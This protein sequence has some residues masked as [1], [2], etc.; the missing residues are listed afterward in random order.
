M[1][2]RYRDGAVP[3]V[4]TDPA[5]AAD[6]AALPARSRR[7]DRAEATTALELIWQRVRRLN[8]Y[9]EERAPWQLAKDPARAAALDE[10][11]ASMHEGVRALSVLL[12]PYMPASTVRLLDALGAPATG[13]QA[14]AFAPHLARDRPEAAAAL[15]KARGLTRIPNQR[16][17]Q[18]HASA[19]LRPVRGC[20][21]RG[22]RERRPDA[23]SHRRHR[24]RRQ[25]RSARRRRAPRDGVRGDRRA[26]QRGDRLRR[27]GARGPRR[28]RRT[29]EMRRDRRDRTRLLPRR[30]PRA[31]TS[32]APSTL[33]S[34][35]PAAPTRRSSSTRAP[36]T[37]TRSRRS[38]SAPATCA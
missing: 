2:V 37:R 22:R 17:R 11:L 5:L 26:P 25:P 6:F 31:R 36:P 33:R 30:A 21:D 15:P 10:T 7:L 34:T 32:C 27:A 9:A 38:A 3:A 13:F 20:A 29:P 28:A 23:Y 8:R 1:L 14:A 16:D 35:S 19:P 4:S 18:P 12:H 24:R